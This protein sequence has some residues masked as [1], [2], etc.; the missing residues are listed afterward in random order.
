MKEIIKKIIHT[1]DKHFKTTM[2]SKAI[3]IY[4]FWYNSDFLNTIRHNVKPNIVRLRYRLGI[5]NGKPLK[6]HLGCGNKRFEGYINIDWRKTGATDLVCDIR[7]LPYNDNSVDL[8]ETYHIIEHLPRR[9]LPKALREWRRVLIPGGKLIIECPDFDKNL[10]DY[11]K[12][13]N[14]EMQLLYIYGRQRFEGDAHYFGYN[15]E[16]L[17]NILKA[18]GFSDIQRKDAQDYHTGEAACLRVKCLA[19]K[20]K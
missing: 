20:G 15:F 2:Y 16:R 12:N 13:I 4:E 19:K 5:K 18:C 1:L 8:I 10:Q 6:L 14:P 9:E 17:K 7:N 11:L 3:K